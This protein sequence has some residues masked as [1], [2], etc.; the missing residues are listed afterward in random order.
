M[1]RCISVLLL[2]AMLLS[3]CPLPVHAETET[4][5]AASTPT[6][7]TDTTSSD[8]AIPM[9]V[10]PTGSIIMNARSGGLN[11]GYRTYFELKLTPQDDQ[12][13][14]TGLVQGDLHL[15]VTVYDHTTGEEYPEF[16]YFS[17]DPSYDYNV[18]T[19]LVRISATGNCPKLEPKHSYSLCIVVKDQDGNR[20][21]YGNSELNAF[22]N[23]TDSSF[24]K[25]GGIEAEYRG[26]E[27]DT[28]S[29]LSGKSVLFIG[30]SITEASFEN[31]VPGLADIAG[32]AGR[33][34]YTNNMEWVNA[35]VSSAT[36]GSTDASYGIM[37]QMKPFA[38]M[39]RKF[40]Y[41]VVHGGVNDCGFGYSIGSM[42]TSTVDKIVANPNLVSGT[43]YAAGLE[44]TFAYIRENFPDAKVLYIMNYRL[45]S[46]N[47]A[48]NKFTN[49]NYARLG[50]YFTVGKQICNK[51]GVSYVDL[52][53]NEKL[54]TQMQYQTRLAIGDELHPN[55]IGYDMVSPY[56]SAMLRSMETGE[57]V[58]ATP[59]DFVN[60]SAE[61]LDTDVNL[62]L[63]KPAVSG[64]GTSMPNVTN[65]VLDNSRTDSSSVNTLPSFSDNV[66]GTP[67]ENCYVQIDLGETYIIEKINVNM[68]Q[69]NRANSTFRWEAYTSVDGNEWVNV[70]GKRNLQQDN[71]F[72][73]AIAFSPAAARY[74]RIC[75]TFST[76]EYSDTTVPVNEIEVYGV[77]HTHEEKIIPGK[78]ATCVSTGLTDETVCAVCGAVLV[79]AEV[80]EIDPTNHAH[81][82]SIPATEATCGEPGKS[83]GSRCTDCG[84][85]LVEPEVDPDKPATGEHTWE[86]IPAVAATCTVKGYKA[87]RRCTVCGLTEREEIAP[88]GHDSEQ[89]IPAVAAT[90]SST[91]LTEGK[92]CS[93]CGKVQVAQQETAKDPDRHGA[94]IATPAI[95]ATC[96][97]TGLTAGKVCADCGKTI[98]GRE[99]TALNPNRHQAVTVPAV[100][101]TC[102]ESGL[103]AGK[104]CALCGK[105][106]EEQ[107]VIEARG[108]NAITLPAVAATCSSTGLTEG[109]QCFTCGEVLKEQTVVAKTAHT[110]EE[111]PT[112]PATCT[113]TGHKGGTRCAVCG[114]TLTEPTEIAKAAHVE[115]VIPA[116]AAT[117]KSA[118]TTEGRRCIVCGTVTV[119]PK[120]VGSPDTSK[121][122][123][124]VVPGSSKAGTLSGTGPVY[125][126][127]CTHQLKCSVCGDT[128][129]E[130]C[131]FLYGAS[132]FNI[133]D[134]TPYC[135][136]CGAVWA[137]YA[138]IDAIPA[139]FRATVS[140]TN[141]EILEK[142]S[143]GCAHKVTFANPIGAQLIG[144]MFVLDQDLT[145]VVKGTTAT[146]TTPGTTDARF[147]RAC[148]T[149]V[150]G[151]PQEVAA[152]THTL[153]YV[154][155][156]DGT[157]TVSCTFEGCNYREENVA[158]VSAD[159]ENPHSGVCA[160]CGAEFTG[161]HVWTIVENTVGAS[162][163][164]GA[165]THKLLCTVCGAEQTET[166]TLTAENAEC[167]CGAKYMADPASCTH[168]ETVLVTGTPA[169][170]TAAGHTSEV[171]CRTC[172][173]TV[174]AGEEIPAS[175]HA[176]VLTDLGETHAFVCSVCGAQQ[177]GTAT[178]HAIS[179]Y[180]AASDGKHIGY[181]SC[182]KA[183]TAEEAHSEQ[184]I[185]ITGSTHTMACTLCGAQTELEHRFEKTYVDETQHSK[186]CTVCGLQVTEPHDNTASANPEDEANTH[187][188]HCDCKDAEG[189]TRA[190]ITEAHAFGA[191]TVTETQ[192]S[193]VCAVCGYEAAEAHTFGS[194][195][196]DGTQHW[197][198][199][200]VC[201]YEQ[202]R[203][204]HVWTAGTVNDDGHTMTCVC[205][206]SKT[207]AHTLTLNTTAEQHSYSCSCG[208]TTQAE[209]HDFAPNCVDNGDGSTHSR[210]CRTCGYEASE[211]HTAA[212]RYDEVQH[213][214]E[215]SDCR[216][217]QTPVAHDWKLDPAQSTDE[218]HVYTCVCGATKTEEHNV[219]AV[220][221]A[222]NTLLHDYVCADCGYITNIGTHV[223][224]DYTPVDGTQHSRTC[225]ICGAVRKEAHQFTSSFDD[226]QHKLSC[227]LCGMQTSVEKHS[228]TVDE[229]KSDD[230]QHTLVCACGAVKTE[231]HTVGWKLSEDGIGETHEQFC[232]V[233]GRSLSQPEAHTFV[234]LDN[235]NG[236]TH[237]VKCSVCK[238]RYMEEHNASYTPD[239]D[240]GEKHIL[241]CADC[242]A[243]YAVAHEFTYQDVDETSHIRSC[244]KCGLSETVAHDLV[245]SS[246]DETGHTGTCSTCG[247]ADLTVAH[248]MQVQSTNPAQHT[249]R[250]SGCAYTLK[251]DHTFVDGV[252]SACGYQ[253][254]QIVNID[255]KEVT[256][257]RDFVAHQHSL[258]NLNGVL[259]DGDVS[260]MNTV[261][262]KITYVLCKS[263]TGDS[264]DFNKIRLNNYTWPPRSF[265]IYVS[266]DLQSWTW[267][268]GRKTTDPDASVSSGSGTYLDYSLDVDVTASAK[269]VL[270]QLTCGR[271]TYDDKYWALRGVEFF[272]ND[273]KL[274]VSTSATRNYGFPWIC[275][276]EGPGIGLDAPT[277]VKSVV[278]YTD[279]PECNFHIV[280]T[281]AFNG[282]KFSNYEDY[283]TYKGSAKVSDG[284]YMHVFEGDKSVKYIMAMPNVDL[285]ETGFAGSM[286]DAAT[287]HI[288][289]IKVYQ[290][291]TFNKQEPVSVKVNGEET[292]TLTDGDRNRVVVPIGKQT[293][294][295]VIV[296]FKEPT[297]LSK[298]RAFTYTDGSAFLLLATDEETVTSSTTWKVVGYKQNA[299][300]ETEDN[301]LYQYRDVAVDETATI[302]HL[303]I[304][305]YV[306]RI[307]VDDRYVSLAE[308][309]LTTV[310]GKILTS[311]DIEKVTNTECYAYGNLFNKNEGDWYFLKPGSGEAVLEY[312]E[313]VV[314]G[315]IDIYAPGADSV[316]RVQTSDDGENW[317][318]V[319]YAAEAEAYFNVYCYTLKARNT[320]KF[321][322][323]LPVG[324]SGSN[325]GAYEVELY[326]KPVPEPGSELTTPETVMINGS[327]GNLATSLTDDSHGIQIIPLGDNCYVDIELGDEYEVGKVVVYTYTDHY[328]F[329]IEGSTDGKNWTLI[330][331]NDDRPTG[332]SF[333]EGY[334]VYVKRGYYSKLRITGLTGMYDH[335]SLYNIDV[336][337]PEAAAPD[338]DPVPTISM[339]IT[340]HNYLADGMMFEWANSYTGSISTQRKT[341]LEPNSAYQAPYFLGVGSVLGENVDMEEHTENP[342]I[343]SQL[344]LNLSKGNAAL[345]VINKTALAD[346]VQYAAVMYQVEQNVLAENEFALYSNGT[347]LLNN[348]KLVD[349]RLVQNG[350]DYFVLDA[351]RNGAQSV[352]AQAD[353][354]SRFQIKANEGGTYS[355]ALIEKEQYTDETLF[356]TKTDDGW[357]AAVWANDE[358]QKFNLTDASGQLLTFSDSI[359][360]TLESSNGASKTVNLETAPGWH[361]AVVP[362]KQEGEFIDW[363]SVSAPKTANT[364]VALA[365]V[366]C[367]D[368]QADAMDYSRTAGCYIWQIFADNGYQPQTDW[369]NMYTGYAKAF[370][371]YPELCAGEL[372][373]MRNAGNN[374]GFS[375][376]TANGRSS[377]SDDQYTLSTSAFGYTVQSDEEI[378]N[379]LW[380]SYLLQPFATG[381]GYFKPDELNDGSYRDYMEGDYTKRNTVSSRTDMN[382]YLDKLHSELIQGYAAI[383][384]TEYELN[385]QTQ[386][387]IY[388]QDTVQKMAASMKAALE[389]PETYETKLNI[390]I[391][392]QSLT[393]DE[394]YRVYN[395][396]FVTGQK[397]ASL[398]GYMADGKTARDLAQWLREHMEATGDTAILATD[399]ATY[400]ADASKRLLNKSWTEVAGSDPS[401]TNYAIHNYLDF[402]YWFMNNLYCEAGISDTLPEFSEI[403]FTQQESVDADGNPSTIYVFNGN[404]GEVD[405]DIKNGEISNDYP[406]LDDVSVPFLPTARSS[407]NNPLS[408][409]ANLDYGYTMEGH[410]KFVFDSQA[411]QYFY[412]SGDDDVYLFI[413]DKLVLDLGGGHSKSIA[414]FN[415][416]DYITEC[417]LNDGEE[418][419]F[420]FFYM[421]RHSTAANIRIETNIN[422]V[423]KEITTKKGA[424]EDGREVPN[425]GGVSGTKELDYYF[426]ITNNYSLEE[427]GAV[428]L[429]D[430][431]FRDDYLDVELTKELVKLSTYGDG[432][433]RNVGD[434]SVTVTAAD[435]TV[436]YEAKDLTEEQLKTILAAVPVDPDD[437]GLQPGQTFRISGIKYLLTEQ[438]REDMIFRNQVFTSASGIK[439]T[440]THTV[441]TEGKEQLFLWNSHALCL[442]TDEVFGEISASLMELLA[443]DGYRIQLNSTG[444]LSGKVQFLERDGE[445]ETEINELEVIG[446]DEAQNGRVQPEQYVQFTYQ[447]NGMYNAKFTITPKDSSLLEPFSYTVTLV[448]FNVENNAYVLDYGLPVKLN[449]G[450]AALTANDSLSVGSVE[451]S[452]VLTGM[453]DGDAS[454]NRMTGTVDGKLEA[455]KLTPENGYGYFERKD[456]G[457]TFVSTAIMDGI[458][459]AQV[460]L[461]LSRADG[462][463]TAGDKLDVHNQ[464]EMYQE[465]RIVPASVVYYDDNHGGLNYGTENED[466]QIYQSADQDTPYG[467]DP[468]YAGESGENSGG[469]V[470][471]FTCN[472]QKVLASFSFRGTGFEVIS[473]AVGKDP[474]LI[475]VTARKE[476]AN[477]EVVYRAS[478]YTEY[479]NS[480]SGASGQEAVYQVPVIKKDFDTA[481]KYY[482][483]IMAVPTTD[484]SG[485]YTYAVENGYLIFIQKATDT[486]PERRWR[487]EKVAGTSDYQYVP[488]MQ[489]ETGAW[490]VDPDGEILKSAPNIIDTSIYIDGVRIYNPL[491]A[492]E[493]EQY[494]SDTEKYAKFQELRKLIQ[495]GLIGSASY[496]L[497]EESGQYELTLGMDAGI[498]V[499]NRNGKFSGSVGQDV[500]SYLKAGPN[501]EVYLDGTDG[502]RALVFYVKADEAMAEQYRTL[503]LAARLLNRT[504]LGLD[505]AQTENPAGD[506]ATL[507]ISTYDAE[508]GFGWDEHRITSATEQYYS[509]DMSRCY[510]HPGEDGLV[511]T[512]DDL[513]YQVMIMV[514]GG[515]LSLT[516]LKLSGYTLQNVGNVWGDP[517]HFLAY[518]G[519]VSSEVLPDLEPDAEKADAIKRRVQTAMTGIR[520]AMGIETPEQPVNDLTISGASLTLRSD[521]SMNFYVREETLSGWE[522]AYMRFAKAL[523][524]A[525]GN[526]T[527][528]AEETV[529]DYTVKNGCRVYSFNGIN[530]SEMSS[531]VTA[532][533]F[534]AQNGKEA[535]S[536]T[537]EYS[538]V[539][540]VKNT[541]K[542]STDAKLNT[543]LVD[544]LNYGTEA[545]KYW[546][547]HLT[548]LANACLTEEQQAM[549]TSTEP[550]L[551]NDRAIV[552]NEGAS[553]HF[554]GVALTF[555]EK[556]AMNVYLNV[557]GSSENLEAVISYQDRSGILRSVTVDGSKFVDKRGGVYAVTFDGLDP[558]QM[559]TV[560]SIQVFDRSTGACVSDTL[561]YSIVSYA[562]NK[563]NDAKLG[564]LVMAMIRYGDSAARFFQN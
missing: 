424:Y 346:T 33:V 95:P 151:E 202:T 249:L 91:G 98:E 308:L 110:P 367:F 564:A 37:N 68:F 286:K 509:I 138:F 234:R 502:A 288:S 431:T 316:F 474:A 447:E 120:T 256:P 207:E 556:V 563:Q 492:E 132:K 200:T 544:M 304:Q 155:N 79:P 225:R 353:E 212:F 344:M 48:Y 170:C 7:Q 307:D 92:R 252:C 73:F 12:G 275:P 478:V 341:V 230:T 415:L 373:R 199:C 38:E 439:G 428:N 188:L 191:Y 505:D 440:A 30:D 534:A 274:T 430:L 443:E 338:P 384:L 190:D 241:D 271:S 45:K 233:C 61:I 6:V 539:T 16:E 72:G 540:Y 547:Y 276:E 453:L 236:K 396:S 84:E 5:T 427:D 466:S 340:I 24:V 123:Y 545:Q 420:D 388:T 129:T 394:P 101:A 250:C 374:I 512:E 399:W 352:S 324:Y 454:Y 270:I 329:K 494:Y 403:V 354:A 515:A 283:G 496:A 444:G 117:C 75:P 231:A 259:I 407:T 332:Y 435:G 219:Q 533:L 397:D 57:T 312:A 51:W 153:E 93:R 480:E 325:N 349:G 245:A 295:R 499:E 371:Q 50:N 262:G 542:N 335:F 47:D 303:M 26:Y 441:V 34:G 65:G 27:V 181:C 438:Q 411:N 102:T 214:Y 419:D 526:I 178:A 361:I 70:G 39:G 260:T 469:L 543:L 309:E 94:I 168:S 426:E 279:S 482:V 18:A 464:V 40:D 255:G 224:T 532:T 488:L 292:G 376:S 433:A 254:G 360:L 90:C 296:S 25:Y 41:I 198:V 31:A 408:G 23:S 257:T 228:W 467:S 186:K 54:Y 145:V 537:V 74:V 289:E 169:T 281:S 549:A 406:D 518:S 52:Y 500:N 379:T 237:M 551:V 487:R 239:P 343:R 9:L 106:L 422:I 49:T 436:V 557:A 562:K 377:A 147:C 510:Y 53:N 43:N 80:L 405:Y 62:A 528:Y 414:R 451:T 535:S 402:A 185:A 215:C 156:G 351:V 204:D 167:A 523:Y 273:T 476:D 192:H 311:D 425:Y 522:N 3:V 530:A 176:Y 538:V 144:N 105:V 460:A 158:H 209:A 503:Q 173:Q 486:Q 559:R 386:T 280:A 20:R 558:T 32:W 282:T 13:L 244:A 58:K 445:T 442:P 136:T 28:S 107:Q 501:N 301:D 348:L 223:Y 387:P 306:G 194:W 392:G 327:N 508:N 380:R 381:S 519:G 481:G 210:I 514:S 266:D 418:Y 398:Y 247:H 104:K 130:N 284:V 175:G 554:K 350:T 134:N 370:K 253:D 261:Q 401:N 112:V 161:E 507:R 555:K 461:R 484:K 490:V 184:A 172:Y 302:R 277:K 465:L 124:E 15:W 222:E 356:L 71:F 164:T 180:R 139:G 513:G 21:Y 162:E 357:C 226:E 174:T 498:F 366:A 404:N 471:V 152:H 8:D 46:E 472:E 393:T 265:D 116:Q 148:K 216:Y 77:S 382:F 536:K 19:G 479:H 322:R 150:D 60:E 548:E 86:S 400:S 541:L 313:G 182:G 293:A 337:A 146:E 446:T 85:Y 135:S 331:T 189:Q 345:K 227:S 287:F 489:D 495:K 10:E 358:T 383:G 97:E 527:G 390:T 299:T 195:R 391:D 342:W 395:Q 409:G 218:G 220:E 14:M 100:A 264:L 127:N 334:T 552:E 326:S 321:I 333:S 385:K 1:K 88:L 493:A 201:G 64:T 69:H 248:T 131:Q 297:Q 63:G 429:T 142:Q 285:M 114:E 125:E 29:P 375:M 197:R 314:D 477:G 416:N 369:T 44:R 115:E 196:Y 485:A 137:G 310:D 268:T 221:N 291:S 183:L 235:G 163:T 272:K 206:A 560:C 389:I 111:I 336:F 491:S 413:N 157:H 126:N 211:P 203:A 459:S 205:G 119:E 531:K 365:Y 378:D 437:P 35:G 458:T 364:T 243:H 208:Y 160:A 217:E 36:I 355:F 240:N 423:P 133:M 99:E 363:L 412:F 87:G 320:G 154:D 468:Q 524:D 113:E 473:R 506:P 42:S 470:H 267:M 67:K 187:V 193:A 463:F 238:Q 108:H 483:E 450:T 17:H 462:S 278:V 149:W 22:A 300:E 232:R 525:D 78:A 83:A 263:P 294:G 4:D 177:P 359:P 179:A 529:K 475:T 520:A 229:D 315:K 81:V 2:L 140:L 122:N 449:E 550:T 141:A 251:A 213:W 76:S 56:I 362:F 372:F 339:P 171:V 118:A 561:Q 318:E 553:V 246:Y 504:G 55:N 521:I 516:N 347:Q 410:G 417:G 456:N 546:S 96:S 109:Q 59:Y 328:S 242:G 89:V 166:V 317:T 511:G 319:G 159:A 66:L 165:H 121:H 103:T 497:N 298:L 455:D 323:V 330:G 269:Y 258:D 434:L 128:K 82:V 452:Y 457:L 305:H 517:E 448:V 143:H 421:E 290:S 432:I 11:K 368:S